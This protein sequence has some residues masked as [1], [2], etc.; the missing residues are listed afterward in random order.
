MPVV[1][2]TFFTVD[3]VVPGYP[4]A[5]RVDDITL[6]GCRLD[7]HQEEQEYVHQLFHSLFSY[8]LQASS[9][10]LFVTAHRQL[11]FP[12][13]FFAV[14]F[15]YHRERKADAEFFI[16]FLPFSFFLRVL[17]DFSAFFAVEFL[18]LPQRAQSRRRV[19]YLL[20]SFFIFSSRS[21]RL[22]GVLCG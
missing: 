4:H 18:F 19:F 7:N 15:F 8:K 13:A 16:C 17:C 21:L 5:Y 10:K 3:A 9:C 11:H 22:L 12:F 6:L 1:G 20:S 14:N 2:G